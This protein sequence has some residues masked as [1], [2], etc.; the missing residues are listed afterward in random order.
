[1]ALSLS[2]IPLPILAWFLS[3]LLGEPLTLFTKCKRSKLGLLSCP[4]SSNP[5]LWRGIS[6]AAHSYS[7]SDGRCAQESPGSDSR[8]GG[9]L[10][11]RDSVRHWNLASRI[12]VI[13]Q[14]GYIAQTQI[15]ST[16]RWEDRFFHTT[17]KKTKCGLGSGILTVRQQQDRA[18]QRVG[19]QGRKNRNS[20]ASRLC[21]WECTK[22]PSSLPPTLLILLLQ[23][24]QNKP[25]W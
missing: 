19:H 1:M 16:L 4:S 18:E 9:V 20:C 6:V 11:G 21:L 14:T 7:R 2:L 15:L 13:D 25:R 23:I 3:S 22:P 8:M 5:S 10:G 12:L 17:G 24:S